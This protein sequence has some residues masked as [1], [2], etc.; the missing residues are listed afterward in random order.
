MEVTCKSNYNTNCIREN[1]VKSTAN[2]PKGKEK[3]KRE[4]FESSACK[5]LDLEPLSNKVPVSFRCKWPL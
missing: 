3:E 2:D 5:A 4:A 1:A